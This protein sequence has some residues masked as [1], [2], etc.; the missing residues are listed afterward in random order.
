MPIQEILAKNLDTKK[1]IEEQAKAINDAV[2]QNLAINA[3]S[4]G[5]D[6]SA[7]TMI[8][9]KALGDR[10]KTYFINNGLMR[11]GEPESVVS[12]FRDMGVH[13]QL[14]DAREEF[15][16]ALKGIKDPEEKREAITQTFYKKVFGRLVRESG[17]RHLLQG[18]IL[19]D[20]D[21]TVAGIKRQHNVF[22]QLGINPEEAFGYRILE[23]LVQL[24]KDGV[25]KVAEA[26]GLPESVYNRM[27]FPGPA[28]S[29]RVIGEATPERIA[30]VRKATAITEEVLASAEAFQYMAILH[31][32]RVTGMRDGKRDFGL[33]IEIRCWDSLDARR[34][35]P[36]R[37]EW[38]ILEHLSL[39]ILDEVPNVVSVTYNIASK[40][41]STMEAV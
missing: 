38:E 9:H 33:Q 12:L 30:L 25:R 13:V 39:R 36:T 14:I 4:G 22:E 20:V 24:R 15:F 5:V 31:E 32:D 8:G 10:L 1:F 6:S 35:V 26:L 40:P 3:L 2:G 7:V 11:E 41:P 17:A 16:K 21:E 28:L 34:A 27:P 19:T 23:P 37:L 18:T 29:A